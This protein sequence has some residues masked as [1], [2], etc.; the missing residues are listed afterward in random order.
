M[1]DFIVNL[2]LPDAVATGWVWPLIGLVIAVLA[3]AAIQRHSRSR[4]SAVE[5]P[6]PLSRGARHKP[7]EHTP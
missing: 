6:L 2:D 5:D 3:P 7:E 4:A 1:H